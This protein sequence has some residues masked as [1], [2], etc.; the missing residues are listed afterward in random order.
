MYLCWLLG[1]ARKRL[2]H[3]SVAWRM[4]LSGSV[5]GG[6]G[7]GGGG[8][9]GGWGGGGIGLEERWGLIWW[10]GIVGDVD[11]RSLMSK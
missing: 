3:W 4:D 8:D 11:E 9:N 6:V 1:A 2:D 5:V 10:W 7:G